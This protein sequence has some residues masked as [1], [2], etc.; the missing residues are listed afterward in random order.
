MTHGELTSIAQ[1][2]D[3]F[4]SE[5]ELPRFAESRVSI[6]LCKREEIDALIE[7]R[8]QQK[9]EVQDDQDEVQEE[10]DQGAQDEVQDEGDQGAQDEVQEE[11]DQGAQD[12]IQDDGSTITFMSR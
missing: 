10:G 11:G 3:N 1:G 9:D 7:Y 12:E 8:K 6:I 2:F 5:Y 4:H